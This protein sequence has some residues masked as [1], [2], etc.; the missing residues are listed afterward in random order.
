VIDRIDRRIIDELRRDARISWRELADRVHLAPSSVADRVRRLEERGLILG[1]RAEVDPAAFGR[2]VRAVIDIGLPPTL[3]PAT[4]EAKLAGRDEV[5]FA[6]YV[7]GESDYTIV[8]DCAG[9]AGLDGFIRW[10]KA[11]AGVAR[12]ESKFVLRPIVG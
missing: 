6:A 10:L 12:T 1:Y 3:D 4:F 9:A 5:A 7:T 8:V 11:E 2:S